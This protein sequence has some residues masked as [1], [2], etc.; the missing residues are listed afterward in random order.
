MRRKYKRDA[1]VAG[2]QKR[3]GRVQGKVE[4]TLA[5]TRLR[6]AT[7]VYRRLTT[8][9][10]TALRRM[11]DQPVTEHRQKA[12]IQRRLE[13]ERYAQAYQHQLNMIQAGL[14]PMDI[15]EYL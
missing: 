9:H 8:P 4:A 13:L 12:I 6:W 3:I 1:F 10:K 11:E 5:E 14:Q 7:S 2:V 15:L